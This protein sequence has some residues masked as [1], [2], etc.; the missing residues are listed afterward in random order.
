LSADEKRGKLGV[1][2][3]GG[4]RHEE[5]DGG[6]A[7]GEVVERGVV[8]DAPERVGALEQELSDLKK[9]VVEGMKEN[10]TKLNG[11]KEERGVRSFKGYEQWVWSILLV[12]AVTVF[13]WNIH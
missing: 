7:E 10:G 8:V 1:H 3:E 13:V 4:A 2:I 5:R 9:M 6:L 11:K 12:S